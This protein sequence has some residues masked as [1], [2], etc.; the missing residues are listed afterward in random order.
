MDPL[1]IGLLAGGALGLDKTSRQRKQNERNLPTY[2]EAIRMTPYDRAISNSMRD[3]YAPK[4]VDGPGNVM[5]NA[6]LGA[7][8]GQRIGEFQQQEELTPYYKALLTRQY[9]PVMQDPSAGYTPMDQHPFWS[10]ESPEFGSSMRPQKTSVDPN[11]FFAQES[12]EFGSSLQ[13]Q[14]PNYNLG[15]MRVR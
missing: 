12:P 1:T 8:V 10:Q 15:S 4:E 9:A 13:R 5:Q 14:K 7:N 3:Q 2:L 11:T 6:V